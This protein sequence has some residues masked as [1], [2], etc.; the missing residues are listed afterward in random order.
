SHHFLSP[1]LVLLWAGSGVRRVSNASLVFSSSLPAYA[2]Q[3]WRLWEGEAGR[4]VGMGPGQGSYLGDSA[5]GYPELYFTVCVTAV[6]IH[7][8]PSPTSAF[9]FSQKCNP[10]PSGLHCL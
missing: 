10:V 6:G 3:L 9:P 2:S 8:W 5:F 4:D 7:Q 1:P